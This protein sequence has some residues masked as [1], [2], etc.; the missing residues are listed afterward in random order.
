MFCLTKEYGIYKKGGSRVRSFY[1]LVGLWLGDDFVYG[2]YL[3]F[4]VLVLGF[5]SNFWLVVGFI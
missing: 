1:F 5:L 2:D 4:D 3:Y